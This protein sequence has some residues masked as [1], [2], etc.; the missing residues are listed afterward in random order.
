MG[1]TELG[2]VESAINRS[3]DPSPSDRRANRHPPAGPD[4]VQSGLEAAPRR[5]ARPP[6][7]STGGG[8]AGSAVRPAGRATNQSTAGT[9]SR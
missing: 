7:L 5:E 6:R 9:S 2:P 1:S 4:P 8:T 3:V